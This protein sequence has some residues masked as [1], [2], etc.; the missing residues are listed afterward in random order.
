[1]WGVSSHAIRPPWVARAR[2]ALNVRGMT[3][4]SREVSCHD[5]NS[6]C[7]LP[8]VTVLI[9]NYNTTG[10]LDEAIASVRQQT[11][12]VDQMVISNVSTDASAAVIARHSKQDSRILAVYGKNRGQLATIVAGLAAAVGDLVFLL[13][14]DDFYFLP[15]A[16]R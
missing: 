1:M 5:R 14:V 2:A 7:G 6:E 8:Q 3:E 15:E 12:R 11:R 9:N 13:D 16:A 10:Y 4:E